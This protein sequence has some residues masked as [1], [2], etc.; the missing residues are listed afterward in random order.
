MTDDQLLFLTLMN[1]WVVEIP[2]QKASWGRRLVHRIS[3]GSMRHE[4]GQGRREVWREMG[5]YDK[6]KNDNHLKAGAKTRWLWKCEFLLVKSG[7]IAFYPRCCSTKVLL[8]NDPALLLV[9]LLETSRVWRA[10][11]IKLQEWEPGP[12]EAV[13][14]PIPISSPVQPTLHTYLDNIQ[15]LRDHGLS[16][17]HRPRS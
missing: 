7:Q 13:N 9:P 4:A 3:G 16:L 17:T 15:L 6:S 1:S 12:A 10:N 2:F 8:S 5:K 11:T 14:E